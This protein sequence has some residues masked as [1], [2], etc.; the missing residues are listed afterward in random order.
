[1]PNRRA[2]APAH[3]GTPAL[4]GYC[5]PGCTFLIK[6]LGHRR[7]PCRSRRV[8]PL[9]RCTLITACAFSARSFTAA[10]LRSTASLAAWASARTRRASSGMGAAAGAGRSPPVR[11]R[12]GQGHQACARPI[13]AT[14]LRTRVS[15]C[16]IGSG[17]KG[18]SASFRVNHS[19]YFIGTV[20]PHR[21]ENRSVPC[22]K[23]L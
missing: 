1:M 15:E 6:C 5:G 23:P 9:A 18:C 20:W 12:S 21:P 13:R 7:S 10:I 17:F 11:P 16:V 22:L 14:I 3:R 2:A 8:G 4:P 19:K